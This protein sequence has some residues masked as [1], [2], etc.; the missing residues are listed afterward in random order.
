M[1]DLS[2]TTIP[3]DIYHASH[4]YVR[5]AHSLANNAFGNFGSD[6]WWDTS[7]LDARLS[8]LGVQQCAD[9]AQSGLLDKLNI[10][11]VVIS[12]LR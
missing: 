5:H 10:G 8:D 2:V 7:L 12:P 1:E 11:T 9:A 4:L 3:M 6:S